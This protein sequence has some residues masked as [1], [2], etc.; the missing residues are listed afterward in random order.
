[1][2]K[3][4][5][6]GGIGGGVAVAVA[7]IVLFLFHPNTQQYA[8]SVEPQNEMVMGSGTVVRVY[9]QNTGSDPLTNVKIDYGATNDTLP[10]LNPGQKEMFSPPQ[11]TT[12]VKVTD[13]QG[14]TVSKPISM[15]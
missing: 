2:A 11:G 4:I 5:V 9:V 10:V 15:G 13:D 6:Y 8:L 12:M 7:I 1:M 3:P 14:I